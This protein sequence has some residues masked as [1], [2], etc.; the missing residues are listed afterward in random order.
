MNR[1]IAFS[2]VLALISLS[3]FVDNIEG[4]QPNLPPVKP[5]AE[6]NQEEK[7]VADKIVA[8][9]KGAAGVSI[10]AILGFILLGVASI[11]VDLTPIFIAMYRSHPDTMAISLITI[12][13][14][15]TCIGWWVAV[16]WAVKSIPEQSDVNVT[17]VNKSSKRKSRRRDDED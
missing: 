17:V 4:Q 14:G 1:H 10:C 6:M 7:D 15:W 2:L 5:R 11:V 9:T 8:V 16:I 12:F 13:F 3:A